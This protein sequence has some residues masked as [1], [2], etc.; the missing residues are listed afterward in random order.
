MAF[1]SSRISGGLKTVW[2]VDVDGEPTYQNNPP[3]LDD[4]VR[5]YHLV[6]YRDLCPVCQTCHEGRRWLMISTSNP[7]A[8]PNVPYAQVIAGLTY[9]PYDI[10]EWT[11][12]LRCCEILSPRSEAV[13]YGGGMT[14]APRFHQEEANSH[15]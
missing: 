9:Q 6:Y 7:L 13:Q 2:C 10:D 15:A 11:T 14:R 1:R 12:A 4:L 3:N 5:R 8:G